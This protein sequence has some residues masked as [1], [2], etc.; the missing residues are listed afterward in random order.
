[1]EG[2][3]S[4]KTAGDIVG[5]RLDPAKLRALR[6]AKGW[7]QE[8]LAEK[9]GLSQS[10]LAKLE[11]GRS[12]GKVHET[13]QRLAVALGVP[14]EALV[15]HE[16]GTGNV[17]LSA[18]AA[19]GTGQPFSTGS[20]LPGMGQS[21]PAREEAVE[22]ALLE[23]FDRSRHTFA[24]VDVV[25][26]LLT[27]AGLPPE[28]LGRAAVVLLDTAAQLRTESREPSPAAVAVCLAASLRG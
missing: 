25:R 24:D 14:L 3:D 19:K 22:R 9:S 27:G 23:A 26:G 5:V 13:L 6:G 8:V 7:T 20:T 4:H 28:R 21:F 2:L 1:M 15:M 18:S 17:T 16:P 11:L 12:A 10:F